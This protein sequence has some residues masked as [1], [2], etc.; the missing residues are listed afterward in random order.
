MW[1]DNESSIDYI[2]Y[3]YLV[4]AI[5]DIINNENL[6]PCSIGIYGDWGSGKSSLMSMIEKTYSKDSE[7]LVIKFNGWLFEGYDDAK[8]VLMSRIVDEILNKRTLTPKA[9]EYATKLFQKIDWLKVATQ[10]VKL[11]TSL[12]TAGPAGIAFAG[13][14]EVWNHAKEINYGDVAATNS[15]PTTNNRGNNIQ[16]FHSN[17]EDLI[18]ETGLKKIIVLVDDL[19]RCSPDT[20]IGT[21]EAIKL[22]LFTNKTAFIIGA[23]ERLIKYAVRRRFPEVPGENVEIGRDYLEKLIQYPV[24]IPVMSTSEMTTY[25]NLLFAQIYSNREEFEQV[26]EKVISKKQAGDYNFVFDHNTYRELYATSSPNL[27][28]AIDL[29][30]NVVPVLSIGLNG[31]PRQ[32]KRFLN[33]LLI[34][35]SMATAKGIQLKKRILAKLM[36]LEYFKPEIFKSFHEEQALNQGLIPTLAGLEKSDST[37]IKSNKTLA[38][39]VWLMEWISSEP[40]LA[41]VN[42]QTYFYVSRDRLTFQSSSAQRMSPK[43]QEV[44]QKLLSE[45]ESIRI[46]TKNELQQLSASDIAALYEFISNKVMQEEQGQTLDITWKGLLLIVRMRNEITSQFIIFVKKYPSNR[47]PLFASTEITNFLKANHQNVVD[48]LTKMWESSSNKNLA[49]VTKL[50]KK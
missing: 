3:Q 38:D 18:S 6:L 47:L 49:K 16:E 12:L 27:D 13:V 7:I 50:K 23:D 34:R 31:N 26:R 30:S 10:A 41:T 2:D 33:T 35:L 42:L 21:L 14:Q 28:E 1:N 15:E 40:K 36:L 46:S 4:K 39:D 24:R 37:T 11:G 9:I 45:A 22:F 43:A 8:T 44:L 29:C 48:E 20:I 32:V 17:F 25:I 19:D 5:I